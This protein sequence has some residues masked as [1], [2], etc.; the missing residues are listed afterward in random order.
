[1][2]RGDL[3]R[4]PQMIELSCH[5]AVCRAPRFEQIALLRDALPDQ[6]IIDLTTYAVF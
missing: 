5:G 3:R 6:I 4:Y 2:R 1:M